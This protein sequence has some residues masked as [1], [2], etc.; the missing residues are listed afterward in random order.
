MVFLVV[1][2]LVV[3]LRAVPFF[4]RVVF[5]LRVP[6]VAPVEPPSLLYLAIAAPP[7]NSLPPT[8]YTRRPF[9]VNHRPFPPPGKISP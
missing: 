7:V 5:R 4:F 3:F 6:P 1:F 8:L 2:F 9:L